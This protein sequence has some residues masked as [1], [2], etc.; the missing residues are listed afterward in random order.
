MASTTPRTLVVLPGLD[1]TDVFF[2][3]LL[4]V[5][6]PSVHPVVVSF[7]VSGPTGYRELLDVVRKATADLPPFWVLGSSFSGPLAVLLAA[8]APAR[9]RG[10]VLVASFVRSPR[11]DLEPLRF[12]LVSPVVW[13]IRAGRR[14]PTWL[15]R[16]RD[17]PFRQA[18]AETWQR[19]PVRMLA[20]R[21]REVLRIDV[22]A[23]LVA[24]PQPLLCVAYA[25]DRVVPGQCA[26]EV[27]RHHRNA[28]LVV[29]PGRHLGMFD[30]PQPLAREVVQFI[31]DGR[32]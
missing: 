19:V 10:I 30:D 29:L 8:S 3:P 20:A 11:P 1:G 2:R 31:G 14:L 9:V 27:V 18:K 15:R 23:A 12:A 13:L 16:Q 4:A 25:D 7:P 32:R 26:D 28:H 17:D 5:L 24:C 6:P 22:R 21:A